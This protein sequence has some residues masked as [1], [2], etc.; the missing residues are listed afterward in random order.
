MTRPVILLLAVCFA[1][2]SC[3]HKEKDPKTVN[4]KLG[5]VNAQVEFAVT[6]QERQK[7]L[8]DRDQLD[9]NSGMLFIFPKSRVLKFWMKNTRIP[10][11][12]GFFDDEGVLLR[13]EQMAP[14]DTQNVHQSP[15]PAL[16]ALEM[17]QGWFKAHDI[18][19]GSRLQLPEQFRPRQ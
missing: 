19:L 4:I 2:S 18:P 17:K 14:Y 3:F 5:R 15:A 12:I 1:L 16:Y 9:D 11:D 10:L 7:G 6:Y 8:M 13:V